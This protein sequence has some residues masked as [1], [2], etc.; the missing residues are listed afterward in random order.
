MDAAPSWCRCP[1]DTAAPE[2]DDEIGGEA[3][4]DDTV[5]A[6]FP[7]PPPL[8]AGLVLDTEAEEEDPLVNI[9]LSFFPFSPGLLF[10]SLFLLYITLSSSSSFLSATLLSE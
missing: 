5:V 8:P 6:L 10:L 2:D 3:V 1:D 4:D 7:P 9:F